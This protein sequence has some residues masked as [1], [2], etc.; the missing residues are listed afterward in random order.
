MNHACFAQAAC[1]QAGLSNPSALRELQDLLSFTVPH[2]LLD[3]G[4]PCREVQDLEDQWSANLC[5]EPGF[6]ESPEVFFEVVKQRVQ[7]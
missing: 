5:G 1:V 3:G 7:L 4:L 6:W 2:A